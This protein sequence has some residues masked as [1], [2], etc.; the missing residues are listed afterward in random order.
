MPRGPLIAGIVLAV[1]LLGLLVYYLIDRQ[2]HARTEARGVRRPV[3]RLPLFGTDLLGGDAP[4]APPIAS[5]PSAPAPRPAP[6]MPARPPEPPAAAPTGPRPTPAPRP[7][8]AVATAPTPPVSQPAVRPGDITAPRERP[9]IPADVLVRAPVPAGAA[10]AGAADG[11]AE[12]VPVS[13]PALAAT[14]THRVVA[15]P[16]LERAPTPLPAVEAAMAEGETVRFA[17]PE[18]G[19]LQFLPGRLAIVAGPDAGREIRLVRTPGIDP[20]EISFGRSEGPAYGHVQLL[21][22]TVSRRHAQMTLTDGH[23]SLQNLSATN[24]VVLNGRPLAP[25]EIAPLLVEGDRIEMGEVV[26]QF[27]ER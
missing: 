15:T 26:F 24:P 13:A 5:R 17:I 6:A 16:P 8:A 12:P 4:S 2:R 19:T 11:T 23:W 27:L 3:E 9:A 25:G 14:D 1:G 21:A 10:A 20:P 7:V 22:R 18:E